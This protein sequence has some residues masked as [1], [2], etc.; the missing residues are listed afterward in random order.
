MYGFIDNENTKQFIL[1]LQL[2]L[3]FKKSDPLI[4]LKKKI[5]GEKERSIKINIVPDSETLSLMRVASLDMI[6]NAETL[7]SMI[8]NY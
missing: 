7:E 6:E 3:T 4:D 8:G 5:L 1:Y 2:K